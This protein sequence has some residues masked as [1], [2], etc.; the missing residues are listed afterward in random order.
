LKNGHIAV[1]PGCDDRIEPAGD[2]S[3]ECERREPG[4]IFEIDGH[5]RCFYGNRNAETLQVSDRRQSAVKR[6]LII[7]YR[8]M[9]RSSAVQAYLHSTDGD[10]RE[11]FRDS[12]AEQRP[13]G[14]D[15]QVE[16]EAARKTAELKKIAAQ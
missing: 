13:V 10:R 3:A 4:A 15:P 6:A 11:L 8:V 7:C 9:G 5:E 2:L 12:F 16:G 1:I 14:E